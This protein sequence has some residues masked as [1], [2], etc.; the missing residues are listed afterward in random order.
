MKNTGRLPQRFDPAWRQLGWPAAFGLL[1]LLGAA[2]IALLLEPAWQRAASQA[3]QQQGHRLKPAIAAPPADPAT[4]W[5]LRQERESRV[6]RLVNLASLHGL[7]LPRITLDAPDER[8]SGPHWQRVRMPLRGD[9]GAL[10]AFL[11][12]ALDKDPALAL[13]SLQLRAAE[14]TGIEAELVWALGQRP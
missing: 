7:S 9:Y 4:A 6:R 3:A 2:L 10:R 13:Q 12:D 11:T 8:V 5:P 1:T 14:P